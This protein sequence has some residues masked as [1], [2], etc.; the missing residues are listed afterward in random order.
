MALIICPECGKEFSNKAF[1]CPNCGC[2]TEVAED[3]LHESI[4]KEWDDSDNE[5]IV[6]IDK[7]RGK[8]EEKKVI[9]V[10]SKKR[11]IA[12]IFTG[13]LLLVVMISLIAHFLGGGSDSN[14][15][16]SDEKSDGKSEVSSPESEILLRLKNAVKGDIVEFGNYEQNNI[17][18]DG[19]EVIKWIVLTINDDEVLLLSKDVLDIHMYHNGTS[20]VTWEKSD[21]RAWLNSTFYEEA[22]S[23]EE[24]NLVLS[25]SITT[26]SVSQ[27]YYDS[28]TNSWQTTVRPVPSC[29][30]M[31]KVFVLS[32]SQVDSLVK[33][34]DCIASVSYYARAGEQN[35]SSNASFP[36]EWVLR[37]PGSVSGTQKFVDEDGEHGLGGG[38]NQL[39]F[40]I[41]P[42]IYIDLKEK[43]AAEIDK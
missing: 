36:F 32:V 37:T 41:R 22:F 19:K 12:I 17:K 29:N 43:T 25:H 23:K 27:E 1:C 34:S 39:W 9:K 18:D 2:P 20:S 16:N 15:G 26:E 35:H 7:N 21:L 42:A 8:N 31:D 38:V 13:V 4:T 6:S 24:R 40:G 14:D 28:L 11:L 3:E 10:K 30:T 33:K 5:R